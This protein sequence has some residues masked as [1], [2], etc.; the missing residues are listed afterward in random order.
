MRNLGSIDTEICLESGKC[1]RKGRRIRGA[2]EWSLIL[3]RYD[4][5]GLTQTAFCAREGLFPFLYSKYGTLVAWLGRRR[6]KGDLSG[7]GSVTRPKFQELSLNGFPDS[8]NTQLEV[9]LPDGVVV[10][11][12]SCQQAG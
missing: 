3:K 6:K 8:G 12:I 5:S 10:R 9:A 2:H 1:D 11:G 7:K 4:Q